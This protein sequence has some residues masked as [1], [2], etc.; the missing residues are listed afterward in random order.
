M[1]NKIIYILNFFVGQ[2]E[3]LSGQAEKLVWSSGLTRGI[4][5]LFGTLHTH[6]HTHTHTHNVENESPKIQCVGHE[7]F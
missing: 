2:V 1:K 3:I 7:K 6:T 4:G 5:F